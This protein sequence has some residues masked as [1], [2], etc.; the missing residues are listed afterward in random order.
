MT[1]IGFAEHFGVRGCRSAEIYE[2]Y[3]CDIC[4]LSAVVIIL[5][6]IF[7]CFLERLKNV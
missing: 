4:V 7:D 3:S 6:Y 5:Q 1:A 2:D